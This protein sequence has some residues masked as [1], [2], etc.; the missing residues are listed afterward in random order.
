MGIR[1]ADKKW[2]SVG[3]KSRP[4]NGA[5]FFYPIFPFYVTIVI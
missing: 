5:A 2:V 3:R 1:L 4:G